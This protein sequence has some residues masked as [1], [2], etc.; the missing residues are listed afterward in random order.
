M[1]VRSKIARLRRI[2][3]MSTNQNATRSVASSTDF[4][5]LDLQAQFAGIRAEVVSAVSRV[6]E[7]QHFILG[8]EVDAL[9]KE[10]ALLTECRFGIGCASGSDALLLSL[11]ALDLGPGDEVITSPFTFVA[12]GGAIARVGARPVF[13]DIK[14]DDYNLDP[15][16]VEAA[17]TSRTRAI[18]PV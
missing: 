14:P 4:P 5:F 6:L 7:S 16:Q 12:T 13:V 9:E 2:E 17:I 18:M 11:M 3:G 10:M 1:C 15:Q 8:A